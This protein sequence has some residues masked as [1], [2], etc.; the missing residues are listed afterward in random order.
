MDQNDYEKLMRDTPAPWQEDDL[1][2]R[3]VVEP[4]AIKSRIGSPDFTDPVPQY[5]N[6]DRIIVRPPL[7]GPP[8]PALPSPAAPPPGSTVTNIYSFQMDD[9]TN[10]T[11]K[12][13]DGKPLTPGAKVLIHD[14]EVSANGSDGVV[15]SGM[16]NDDF[17]LN[18]AAD[19]DD[20]WVEVTYDPTTLTIS[21]AT[22]NTG[23]GI[24]NSTLGNAYLLLGYVTFKQDAKGNTIFNKTTGLPVGTDP[25]NTQC[26]DINIAF[27][28][29]AF[30]AAPALFLLS[31]IDAPQ[32][33][34]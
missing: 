7:P 15:P 21:S 16:G 34:S 2:V 13:S 12:T 22:V 5:Q 11:V 14:G 4:T 30:N 19:G 6:P 9:A 8:V 3:G 10:T 1:G 29:G 28:Y 20:V 17:I 27:M 33:L 32:P 24:P 31:Q 23:T 26:G 25:H 18:I